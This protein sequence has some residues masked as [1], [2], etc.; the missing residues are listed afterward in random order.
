M[1]DPQVHRRVLLETAR[2][3]VAHL[4]VDLVALCRSALPGTGGNVEY[5]LHLSAGGAKG[6]ALDTLATAVEEAVTGEGQSR[7][8]SGSEA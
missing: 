3:V 6:L 2:F 8:G 5:F 1:R 4:G 7:G